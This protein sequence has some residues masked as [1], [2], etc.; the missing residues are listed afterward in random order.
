MRVDI[1]G[2]VRLFIDVVGPALAADADRM[3]ERPVLLALHG[4][5]GFD[6][7]V[8]RPWFDRF[9][10]TH[11]VI[12]LDHRGNGRSDGHND[13]S[14]WHLDQWADDIAGL[15]T[16]LDL[17]HI[18]LLGVSFGGAVAVHAAARH[19]DLVERLV[20]ISSNVT[21]DLPA[22]LAVFERRG[23]PEAR[24]AA[25]RHWTDPD[26]DT[27]AAYIERCLPLYTVRGS[28]PAAVPDRARMNRRLM[29][30]YIAESA[31]LDLRDSVAALRCP[32][33]VLVGEDDPVTPAASSQ[34]IA[35]LVPT[36]LGRLEQFADCGH[37][38]QRD[39]PERT[40]AAI[41]AFLAER[42]PPVTATVP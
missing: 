6:H 17:T 30:R 32:T 5:P 41:R 36:G 31:S 10:D 29:Q 1:G 26:D 13:P 22:M 40:D 14:G 16:A 25:E 3:R 4:G 19:P 34:L 38:T 7:S 21:K 20:L 8:L 24:A 9:A 28:G 15:C 23:G 33:L 27:L 42:L 37:G 11:Q 12:Y 18:A 35:S 2:G 39:Q